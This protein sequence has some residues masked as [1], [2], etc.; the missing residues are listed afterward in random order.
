MLRQLNLFF[1]TEAAGGV[2]LFAAA[3]AAILVANSSWHDLYVSALEAPL[4]PFSVHIWVNDAL[5]AIFFFVIGME[6]KSELTVGSLASIKRAIF[7]VA[8][9]VGGMV[10]PVLIFL[11]F[12][13]QGP[14]ARGWAIPMAT[15]IAF[16][17]GVLSLFGRRIPAELKI[18]LLALAI[19]DDLGAVL[20][21]AFVYTAQL[22][23]WYLL[24][25]AVI[26]FAIFGLRR[27]A[28]MWVQIGLGI[29]FW[30]CIH[31]S[32]I[33]ATIAG[34]VLGFL[35]LNPREWIRRLHSVSSFAIM[36]IFAFAN[37]GIVMRGISIG[38]ILTDPLVS[39]VSYGLFIG[40]P[41]GIVGACWLSVRLGFA[42]VSIRW[43][44]LLGVACLGGI[45]F[46]M[47]L[48]VSALALGDAH[49]L[50]LARLGIVKGS[51][52]SAII[53]GVV[54]WLTGRS[55]DKKRQLSA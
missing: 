12:V 3:V 36:P 31:G 42:R 6:I 40:K 45:G 50:E 8:G 29:A 23:A 28:P 52:L 55:L 37:A 39:G 11:C 33:H 13:P 16:A 9:A 43:S 30:I 35:V 10:V 49:L 48:F 51:L 4:G 17:V 22:H 20:I 1:K 27:R 34:C 46:T 25:S 14:A 21:I 41:L 5:M 54:L 7:P 18:F 19:A 15:D 32:G 53:G 24:A 2:I 26:G 44:Q 38:D 47:S